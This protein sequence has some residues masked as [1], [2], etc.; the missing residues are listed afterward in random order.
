MYGVGLIG[1]DC[2]RFLLLEPFGPGSGICRGDMLGNVANHFDAAVNVFVE[3]IGA[4]LGVENSAGENDEREDQE[5][6]DDGDE[7]V[8]DDEAVAQAPEE[9]IAPPADEA[10][11]K[12]DTET[13][14]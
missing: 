9:A 10:D 7:E 12:I 4:E 5:D 14:G 1:E 8:S 11:E 3:E 6:R 2:F 13:E